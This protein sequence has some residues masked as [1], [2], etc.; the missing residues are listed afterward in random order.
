MN[1]PRRP[2]T[3]IGRYNLQKGKFG[4]AELCFEKVGSS[5]NA[6]AELRFEAWEAAGEAALMRPNPK[7]AAEYFRKAAS[8][9]SYPVAWRL[10][11]QLRLGNATMKSFTTTNLQPLQ[12][13][14]E[15][16]EVV[17]TNQVADLAPQAWTRIGDCYLQLARQDPTK[18][19]AATN[20]Y[21]NVIAATNADLATR[22]Q[23]EE[24][25]ALVLEHL[26]ELRPA[27]DAQ[28]RQ[29]LLEAAVQH[30]LIVVNGTNR[31]DG[32]SRD[33]GK[34][35]EA[36]FEAGRLME[37]MQD[38]EHAAALYRTM[39]ADLHLPSVQ[40]KLKNLIANAQKHLAK[41][42]E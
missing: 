11:A 20:A 36:G 1:W 22:C 16:F 10:D 19:A 32:E 26:A 24:C 30:Y 2:S 28:G 9:T 31:R 39:Q 25:I 23:A 18:Y 27:G 33:L 21:A 34:A 3:W 13:A 42:G 7:D 4:D 15:I 35:T 17:A 37:E 12:D 40:T 38:W 14:I 8:D 6:P 41:P 29:Q 5:R